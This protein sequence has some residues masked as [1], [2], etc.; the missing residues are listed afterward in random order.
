[1]AEPTESSPLLATEI[2]HAEASGSGEGNI[3]TFPEITTYTAVRDFYQQP[4]K[5]LTTSILITS[6]LAFIVLLAVD[7]LINH[8]PLKWYHYTTVPSIEA[9]G[10]FVV[11]AFLAAVINLRVKLPILLNFLIDIFL[12]WNFVYWLPEV[13]FGYGFPTDDWCQEQYSPKEPVKPVCLNW[14]LAAKILMGIGGGLAAVVGALHLILLLL[15]CVAA[16]K[17]KFWRRPSGFT[18][19]TG[20]LTFQFTIRLL[21]QETGTVIPGAGAGARVGVVSPQQGPP[22][23]AH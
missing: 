6:I 13:L 23:S 17:S 1:M 8:S 16:W 18:F 4:V 14:V 11:I 7:I 22:E 5:I 20:E 10:A 19:P 3:T 15:R 12:I 9:V 2:N 21:R